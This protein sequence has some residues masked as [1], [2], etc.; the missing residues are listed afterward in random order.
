MSQH[1]DQHLNAAELSALKEYILEK[2]SSFLC[3]GDISNNELTVRV[4]RTF[5]FEFI[6]FLRD[7]KKCQFKSL[8]D[9][10]GVD[11]LGQESS[12][13]QHREGKRFDVV[14]HFL[15]LSLNTRIRV[16]VFVSED[17]SVP[18][19]VELFEGA[20]WYERE[21]FDMF[22]V[23][24][25]NHPDLRRILTDY[26]FDGFPLRKDFPLT[27]HVE[28]YYDKKE[29]R[30]AYKPVDL[31]QDFRNFDNVSPWKG[32]DDNRHLAEQDA[33]FDA[34]EFEEEGGA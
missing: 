28:A 23:Q 5:V 32:M 7:D 26:D 3:W 9:I 22:G 16:K 2:C 25:E 34:S 14:Y 6:K 21:T 10:C 13:G 17:D 31:P 1:I 30:V 20:N 11:W 15:S 12:Q 27:G 18:S 33:V 4:R 24:F 8:V 19:I 29:K